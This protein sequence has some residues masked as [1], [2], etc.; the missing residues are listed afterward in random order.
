MGSQPV[1]RGRGEEVQARLR[2]GVAL[3]RYGM[4]CA[5][6]HDY[7]IGKSM[8]LGKHFM[9][10]VLC[11]SMSYKRRAM[12]AEPKNEKDPPN[13]CRNQLM[14]KKQEIESS[15]YQLVTIVQPE[16]F[17]S[18][19]SELLLLFCVGTNSGASPRSFD[20]MPLSP[21]PAVAVL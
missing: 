7:L 14:Q 12:P 5:E 17:P 20:A 4:L 9:M 11:Y 6:L 2:R 21:S 16:L 8:Y 15:I 18:L 1:W 10:V 13:R 19:L 3:T